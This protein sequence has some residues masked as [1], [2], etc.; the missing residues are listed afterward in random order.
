MPRGPK[1]RL[2]ADR[3]D[4]V[5]WLVCEDRGEAPLRNYMLVC[6]AL[7]AGVMLP[8]ESWAEGSIAVTNHQP[9]ATVRYSV[10]LLQGTAPANCGKLEVKNLSADPQAVPV[11]VVRHKDQFRAL[12]ELKKG[13]NRIQLSAEQNAE[14]LELEL[15]YQEQTNPYYVRLIWMT[16]SSGDTSYITPTPDTP[17]DYESRLRTAALLMQTF[18][19]ERMKSQGLGERTF[20]L[21][22]DA[23]G[24]VVV[25]TWAGQRTMEEYHAM[26]DDRYWWRDVY[27]WINREHPDPLAKNVVLAAYTRKDVATGKMLSH[28]ALGG[29]HLGLFASGSLFSWPT[30]IATVA[31]T[32]QDDTRF[33]STFVNDDSSYRSTIWGVASTT[34]GATLHEM[35]HTFGLPHCTDRYGVM[36]RGFDHFNRCF[37]FYDPKSRVNARPVYFAPTEEA[38]FAP[39]SAS[40]LRWS[41]WFQLDEPTSAKGRPTIKQ[42]ASG[43]TISSFRGIPWV[44]LMVGGEIHHHL[45]YDEQQ[46]PKK[47]TFTYEELDKLVGG[48][49][50]DAIR[51]ITPNGQEASLNLSDR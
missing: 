8:V 51:A 22:H 5:E 16:D 39:V 25:H 2:E 47:V 19:A 34:M 1:T 23:A 36:T 21:E 33:D 29:G 27:D 35:G 38:Y 40:Y 46:V 42:D 7:V 18:T 4:V 50:V 30:S 9:G 41:P 37:T 49:R 31:D 3:T 44:G 45:T 13:K 48:K 43:V 17:Q 14:P 32:Y 26:P 10:V 6:L 20:R 28:T 15:T 24:Q 12:V 11:T